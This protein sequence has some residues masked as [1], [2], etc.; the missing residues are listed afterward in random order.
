MAV[1]LENRNF[2]SWPDDVS[3][4][5]HLSVHCVSSVHVYIW[6]AENDVT[7]E[8]I[9]FKMCVRFFDKSY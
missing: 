7:I 6:H 5:L 4:V 9:W 1:H 3:V 8:L 2:G